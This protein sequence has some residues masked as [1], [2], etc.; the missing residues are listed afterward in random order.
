[1]SIHVGLASGRWQLLT[2]AEQLG[3]IGSEISRTINWKQ[4]QNEAY[5]GRAFDR[6]LELFDLTLADA[7][8]AGRRYELCRAREVV[9]DF[10]AGSNAYHST[11]KNIL[12]YF[13]AFAIQAR[14]EKLATLSD[15]ELKDPILTGKIKF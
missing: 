12:T 11:E 3:N 6:A 4:R 10:F 5:A 9:C 14:L 8:W 1:M 7:R 13:D 2:L 15:P